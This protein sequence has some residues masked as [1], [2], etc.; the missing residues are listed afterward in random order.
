M[1]LHDA[2][3]FIKSS[4]VE[5]GTHL[6]R[7]PGSAILLRYIKSN[8]QNDPVRS[9]VELFLFLFAVRYLLAPKYSTRKEN[10]VKLREDEID[11]LVE[12]W[13]PEPLVAEPLELE[14]VDLDRTP[15]I[16]GP[17]GP[18]VKLSNGKTVLNFGSYNIFNLAQNDYLKDRA[19]ATLRSYGVGPCGPPGFYG[20]QDLHIKT[21]AD[22]ANF[23]G[24]P[25]CIMYAQAFHTISAVIPAFSK[26]G[27]IIVADKACN[28]AI[29]KGLQISRSTIRWYEHNDM[30]D[31][32]RVLLKI[33]K[34][35]ARKPLT[36]RFIVTEG[37]FETM[38]DMSDLPK[39][40]ALKEKYKYRL[41][42]D[43]TYSFLTL[44]R[45][46]RGITEHQN[47]DPN[48]VDMIVGSLSHYCGAGGGFCVGSQEI[49]EHQRIS[50]GAYVFSAALPGILATT[51]SETIGLLQAQGGELLSQVRE[52]TKLFR[53]QIE[54]SEVLEIMS[55]PENPLCLIKLKKD[56]VEERGIEK[57]E[58]ED[59]LLQDIVEEVLS[60]GYLITRVKALPGIMAHQ[61]RIKV[62]VSV[63]HT[64]KEGEKMGMTLRQV[65]AKVV[66][67]MKK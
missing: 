11:E 56:V 31:L 58:G 48:M 4:A 62:V 67:R 7:V 53:Q 2:F 24:V 54:K 33:A 34:E 42:L 46:G 39:I 21:E 25:A 6:R 38:G 32:E 44:G 1:E 43:E 19:V 20:T 64:K 3:D 52:L 30:E 57:G 59:R 17:T 40:M 18:K 66:A 45:T 22:V 35:Q 9:A 50:G 27:D 16:V 61:P 36:R 60:Q 14:Q 23:L 55:V 5:F 8:Y 47:V 37:L 41:I 51:A 29:Q 10:Y 26:R 12:E 13:Q 28:Y 49:V 63:G 65:A 15:T